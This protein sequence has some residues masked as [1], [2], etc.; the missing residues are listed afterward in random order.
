[1][2]TAAPAATH[3]PSASRFQRL[4]L[5]FW[6]ERSFVGDRDVS[7][8][9]ASDQALKAAH[10]WADAEPAIVDF[11]VVPGSYEKVPDETGMWRGFM[12]LMADVEF[13]GAALTLGLA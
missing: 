2:A 12:Q 7:L 8:E 10:E 3:L 1:M 11:E 13:R 9:D 4:V 5:G 6:I